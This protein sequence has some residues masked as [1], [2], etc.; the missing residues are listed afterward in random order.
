M[1]GISFQHTDVVEYHKKEDFEKI[2]SK[3]LYDFLP[4]ISSGQLSIL[5][6][7]KKHLIDQGVPFAITKTY[8]EFKENG[9]M[10]KR[11]RFTLWKELKI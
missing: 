5:S 8:Y 9:R 11:E 7:W 4:D 2:P 6:S 1:D 10:R 3:L